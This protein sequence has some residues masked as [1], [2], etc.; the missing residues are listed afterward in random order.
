MSAG[1]AGL[2]TLVAA[3]AL[4]VGGLGTLLAL[5]NRRDRRQAHFL[6]VTAAQFPPL[7]M[8]SAVAI[9]VH[10]ALLS[11]RTTVAVDMGPGDADRLWATVACLRAALPPAVRLSVQGEIGRSLSARLT[12]DAVSRGGARAPLSLGQRVAC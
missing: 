9:R 4:V 10:C 2:A 12:V 11:S 7:T 8:R 6:G 1:G 5:L 3:L